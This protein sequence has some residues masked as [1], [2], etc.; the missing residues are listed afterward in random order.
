VSVFALNDDGESEPA[1]LEGFTLK[2][3]ELQIGEHST[4]RATFDKGTCCGEACEVAI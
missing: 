3:A 2:V 1:V 4:V